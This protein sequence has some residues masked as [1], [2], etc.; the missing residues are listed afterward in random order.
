M[1]RSANSGK[2]NILTNAA[3]NWLGYASQLVV[4]FFL[5]PI[6][7]GAL[8]NDRYGIWSLVESIL[9]YLF[10]LDFGIGASV[11]RFV[12]KFEA[13]RD[14]AQ[15][16]R[17]FSTSICIFLA[18]GL[19]AM[20]L[21][22]GLAFLVLPCFDKIPADLGPEARWLL[23]ILG[24][25]LGLGLPLK[26]F[27][28]VLDALGRY[29]VQSALR[30]G[31]LLLRTSLLLVVAQSG[32]G[33]VPLAWVIMTC[34]VLE[35]GVLGFLAWRYLPELRFSF[36]L[37]DLDTLKTIRGFSVDAFLAMIAGRISFQT[38]AIVIGAFLGSAPITFFAI[39]SRLVDY[40]KDSLR[41]LTTVLTPAVSV[42]EARG[43]KP[44]I[45]G[46]LFNATRYILWMV[47]PVQVGL[48]ILGKPF[49]ELWMKHDPSIAANGHV[50]LLILATPLVLALPQMVAA[51]ILYGMGRLRWF[52]RAA[53]AEA[54]VNL[55]LSLAL[56]VPLGIQGVALG[57]ALPNLLGS[58]ALVYYICR[59][60]GVRVTAYL[61][62]TFLAPLTTALFLGSGWLA[63]AQW[64]A[65]T[66]WKTLI[67]TGV[68]GLAG[69]GL[70]GLLVE[71][72]LHQILSFLSTYVPLNREARTR[73]EPALAQRSRLN[74]G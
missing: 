10:L 6:L 66:S 7:N 17:V 58:A 29:P 69:Y 4:A 48:M 41:A 8:G 52:A 71:V 22:V 38:A 73:V 53:L 13:I 60:L 27:A 65:V 56:V 50:P 26:V 42:M 57:I 67:A 3:A 46:V 39:A 19:L 24:M 18:A 21:A 47:L 37:A 59:T 11:V 23:I 62:Y 14:Y 30:T 34:N 43:D 25:N 74:E 35:Y 32:G 55:L 28:C 64:S 2:R 9:A 54:L 51:R 15:V 5:T 63:V 16:N 68:A 12:A 72:G 31:G 33:L 45:Q 49:L 36:A 61:R 40:A 44:G 20:G 1:S 70:V